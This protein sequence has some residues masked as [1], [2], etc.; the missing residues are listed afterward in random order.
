MA[1]F[2]IIISFL[3]LKVLPW[4][5]SK[6]KKLPISEGLIATTIVIVLLT[7]WSA[8]YL[9]GV[10][11]IVGAYL[12]GVFMGQTRQRHEIEEKYHTLLYSFFVP[13]FFI[14]I[15]LIVNLQTISG[16]AWLFAGLVTVVAILSK[17]IGC[18]LGARLAGFNNLSSLRLGLGM[19]SRGEVGLI[20]ASVG[21]S[22]GI[23][24]QNVYAAAVL[25]VL[26]T[27]LFTP[28]A[29]KLAF[30]GEKEPENRA[31]LTNTETVEAR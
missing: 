28:F 13:V 16:E 30:K 12:V 31:P 29:L 6:V 21:I 18:G 22:N 7:A 26:V 19:V 15:G 23:I 2:F 8:E 11:M 14:S 5:L 1:A 17:V 25:M 27:T 3:G 24:N 20:V 10:A 4:V 9:G